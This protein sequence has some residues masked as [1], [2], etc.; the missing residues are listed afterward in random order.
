[1]EPSRLPETGDVGRTLPAPPACTTM[2]P[3]ADP[4][5]IASQ[6]ADP[7]RAITG[8]VWGALAGGALWMLALAIVWFI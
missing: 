8:V 3:A 6:D 1:M 4:A 2:P 7:L 5:D